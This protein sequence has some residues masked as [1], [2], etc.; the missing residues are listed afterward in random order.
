[1]ANTEEIGSCVEQI[2]F[3]G[4]EAVGR[5]FAEG[6][7][8]YGKDNW[9]ND[10]SADYRIERCRHAIRHLMLFANGDRGEEHLAKVAWFCLTEIYLSK[11]LGD[12]HD[13]SLREQQNKKDTGTLNHNEKQDYTFVDKLL[14]SCLNNVPEVSM[15]NS[16]N[17]AIDTALERYVHERI[18]KAKKDNIGPIGIR[19]DGAL[20]YSLQVAV[21][22]GI[23]NRLFIDNRTICKENLFNSTPNIELAT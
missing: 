18:D 9:K 17:L 1:M 21:N 2:P 5:I 13:H 6:M 8:K 15:R 22:G 20:V 23:E 11:K 12:V 7:K 4:L 14:V 3:E 19:D 16:G 10:P